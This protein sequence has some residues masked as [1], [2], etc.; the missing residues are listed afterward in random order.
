MAIFPWTSVVHPRTCAEIAAVMS[1]KITVSTDPWAS[2]VHT[3]TSAD[4]RLECVERPRKQPPAGNSSAVEC[5]ESCWG[6][7]S[8]ES[9]VAIGCGSSMVHRLIGADARGYNFGRTLAET[10]AG[11]RR[12]ISQ[13][14]VEIAA[15]YSTR[16][17]LWKLPRYSAD[18]VADSPDAVSIAAHILGLPCMYDGVRH[19]RISGTCRGTTTM[20]FHLEDS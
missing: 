9:A 14:S 13:T 1:L 4:F 10:A 17:Q 6:G 20:A 15:S 7:T 2:G 12:R 16:K 19:G 5:R 8:A 18:F 3:Q 11:N